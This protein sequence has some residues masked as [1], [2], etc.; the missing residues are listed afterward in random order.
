M[1]F[2]R[3]TDSQGHTN[4]KIGAVNVLVTNEEDHF[5][6]IRSFSPNELFLTAVNTEEITE[7][8]G[9][10]GSSK[11]IS[12]VP[13]YPKTRPFLR[14]TSATTFTPDSSA[15]S[16]FRPE[17]RISFLDTVYDWFDQT[18]A[19][20]FSDSVPTQ[21]I[22]L[23]IMKESEF[24]RRLRDVIEVLD[25]GIDDFDLHPVEFNPETDITDE[26]RDYV[27]SKVAKLP[28]GS[29][30][31]GIFSRPGSEVYLLVDADNS[32]DAY[33]LATV[34]LLNDES[35]RVAFDL[36]MESDGTRRL[37]AILPALF[38]LHIDQPDHVFVIDELDRSL[39]THL[40]YNLLDQFLTSSGKDRSQ[41]I[42][43][44]HDTGLLDYDLLRRDEIWFIEKDRNS[45]STLFSLEEFRLPDDMDIKKGYLGGRFGALPILSVLHEHE[46][47][48]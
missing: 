23:G 40:T 3:E 15:T 7:L 2:E 18:L 26:F 44:T 28:K 35:Q 41:L 46:S 27:R 48:E 30:E 10:D 29:N 21:G 43:T 14:R 1:M 37:L 36:D 42:V 32:Y 39:H 34:H 17:P 45:S 8:I 22:G 38:R 6:F 31:R 12:E 47:A 20:V 5:D 9:D 11:R 33:Q 4:V 25:L 13:S 16:P 19:L 24:K